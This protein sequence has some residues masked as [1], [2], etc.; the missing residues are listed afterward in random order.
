MSAGAN[1]SG[2][3]R[4]FQD[5]FAAALIAPAVPADGVSDLPP[6]IARLVAQPGFAVYRNTVLKGCIDALQANY[7]AVSRLVGDEW[8]R[9]AAV[10]Y[11]RANLPRQPSLLDYGSDFAAFLA[12]FEPAAELPYL[13]GV[14]RLD[15]FWTE[16]HVARDEP[17]VAAAAV[18]GFAAAELGR[19]VLH[20]H[21]SA[22]WAWFDDAPI[23]TIWA[24]NRT[25]GVD[26][27]RCG[28]PRAGSRM[29]RRG[30]AD[31]APAR[32]RRV[33]AAGEG[34][35]RVSRCL[36]RGWNA[37][38]C[39]DGRSGRR[40]AG[41]SGGA[42]GADCSTPVPSGVSRST[43]TIRRN[44]RDEYPSHDA[45]P[46]RSERGWRGAWNR[47]ADILSRAISDSLLAL[48]ARFAVA[49][50]FF[51]SGR[52]KVDGWLTLTDGAYA[53]FRDEYKVPLVPP[54][55]AAHLAAYAEH[56]FPL[57]LALGLCTRLSALALLGMT[58]V[59]QVFVYPD[60][61][62]THLSW[63]GLLLLL[64][65]RGGGAMALDRAIGLK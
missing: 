17:P 34:R 49:G 23:A 48:A 64:I 32:R 20:P 59:I 43:T 10:I 62:A 5:G 50:I 56:L 53:L 47:L 6:E 28:K 18:A 51:Q 52:T 14:A 45:R 35:L 29:A 8:F 25:A 30:R 46:T 61:W 24:R 39:R 44:P 57:L 11:A 40:S 37:R 7:P 16:A 19:V 1:P 33:D 15:R 42:D 3:L 63:A 58:A 41:R 4:A 36:R 13:A 27:E 55:I 12:T 31:H 54:E 2:R 21:A 65:G 60:A 26:R 9:A 38:R 22:R